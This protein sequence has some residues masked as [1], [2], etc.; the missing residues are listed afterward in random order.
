MS[1]SGETAYQRT[2]QENHLGCAVRPFGRVG[3]S[4]QVIPLCSLCRF[5]VDDIGCFG[6]VLG[7]KLA[8]NTLDM[9]LYG[10]HRNL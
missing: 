5:V 9:L 6:A 10:L 4:I 7:A 1:G 2:H 8:Q 3:A